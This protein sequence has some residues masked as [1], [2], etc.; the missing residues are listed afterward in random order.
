MISANQWGIRIDGPTA[1]GNLIEGNYVGTDIDRQRRLGNEINGIILSNNASNNT[2]GGTGGGQGNSIAYN[3]Q[4]GVLVQSG[5]GDSILSNSIYFNGQQGIALASGNDLQSC[6]DAHRRERRGNRKQCRG[7]AYQPGEH[8]LSDPVLQQ[9]GRGS[10][11]SGPGADLPGLDG[12]DD[13]RRRHC[14]DQ[15]QCRE[16]PGRSERG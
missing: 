9:P 15:L 7:L 3:V 11:R 4:A 8:E 5:T 2:I 13:R 6:S 1:T 12:C 14:L 10:F 16:R